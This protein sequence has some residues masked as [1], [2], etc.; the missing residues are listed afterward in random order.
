MGIRVEGTLL[1]VIH[2]VA[3]DYEQT[4]KEKSKAAYERL[5]V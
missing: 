2:Q 4:V 3:H 1:E 5:W